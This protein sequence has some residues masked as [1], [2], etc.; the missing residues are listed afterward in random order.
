MSFSQRLLQQLAMS[1]IG[2]LDREVGGLPANTVRDGF[3]WGRRNRQPDQPEVSRALRLQRRITDLEEQLQEEREKNDRLSAEAVV[4]FV[5][6]IGTEDELHTCRQ[7]L[8]HA[9]RLIESLPEEAQERL[10]DHDSYHE[11][12]LAL[13][14][15]NRGT[16]NA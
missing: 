6:T 8:I 13:S 15:A 11:F 16:P 1:T 2:L 5:D 3:P 7:G 14:L 9:A 4:E 10:R 12:L